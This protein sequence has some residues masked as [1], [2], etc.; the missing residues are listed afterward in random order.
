MLA[1]PKAIKFI[2]KLRLGRSTISKKD[3]LSAQ[4]I[5]TQSYL[6]KA[7]RS[8]VLFDSSEEA[9]KIE[10][11]VFKGVIISLPLMNFYK[12]FPALRCMIQK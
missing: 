4:K 3:T 9:A 2:Y 12:K 5:V 11:A 6:T 1:V 8:T 10:K 7:K